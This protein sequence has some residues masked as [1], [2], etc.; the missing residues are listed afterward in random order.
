MPKK[1]KRVSALAERIAAGKADPISV[2]ERE[3]V[4]GLR[5]DFEKKYGGKQVLDGKYD[6]RQQA[7]VAS[8]KRN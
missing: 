4:A 1:T 6:R 2:E 5:A 7:K 8:A 3:I